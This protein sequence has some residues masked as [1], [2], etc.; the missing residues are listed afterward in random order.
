EITVVVVISKTACQSLVPSGY[1]VFD[2]ATDTYRFYK[3]VA[4]KPGHG[5]HIMVGCDIP[6][7]I[8]HHVNEFTPV[9]TRIAILKHLGGIRDMAE[10]QFTVFIS[11]SFGTPL[12]GPFPALNG[13]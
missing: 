5:T 11:G 12:F 10:H 7:V 2:I 13:T 3:S 8:N 4:G 9:A 1:P 6:V